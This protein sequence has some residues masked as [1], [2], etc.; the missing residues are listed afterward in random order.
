M[1]HTLTAAR[2][3]IRDM[4]GALVASRHITEEEAAVA[5][6]RISTTTEL[7]VAVA[8]ADFV[9]E[10]IVEDLEIKQQVRVSLVIRCLSS[11]LPRPQPRC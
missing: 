10:A 1:Q 8:V 9:S 4:Y 11:P 3:A 7:S 2:V 5:A 6:S